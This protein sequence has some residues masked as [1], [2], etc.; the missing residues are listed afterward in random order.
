VR[1]DSPDC[2]RSEIHTVKNIAPVGG[3]TDPALIQLDHTL[4]VSHAPGARV[5]RLQPPVGPLALTLGLREAAE[6]GDRTIFLDALPPTSPGLVLSSAGLANEFH[7]VA[8]Y[9]ATS[10]G[11]G[12]FRLPPIHRL[13]QVRFDVFDGAAT[14]PFFVDPDYSGDEQWLEL[15]IP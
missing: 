15:T 6:R 4:L 7:D 1:I 2:E 13:A 10:D 5:D 12:Y 8:M 9:A 11:A 14:T 3:V